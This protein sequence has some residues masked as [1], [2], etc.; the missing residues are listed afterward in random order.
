MKTWIFPFSNVMV[1]NSQES[2]NGRAFGWERN[3][4]RNAWLA[5]AF[6]TESEYILH[7]TSQHKAGQPLSG[8]PL[9]LAYRLNI[10]ELP[11]VAGFF[12]PRCST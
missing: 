7:L 9:Q 4:Q 10:G 1:N 3:G 2:A 6:K 8:P 5:Y 12:P 11:I